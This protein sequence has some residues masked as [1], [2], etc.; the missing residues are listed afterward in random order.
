MNVEELK[1]HL[2][3]IQ[4]IPDEKWMDE[5]DERKQR[6]LEFHNLHRDKSE[7]ENVDSDTFE[8]LYGNKKYYSTV[9]RSREYFD[10]WI[11][12]HAE[13]EIV[14]DYAC[15][16]G[17][18]TL[19]AAKAGAKL[20]IGFD[21]SDVSVGNARAAAESEGLEN[22][23]FFQADAEDTKLPDGSVDV[24][25]C[26]GMLHHLDLSY[27]FPEMRRILAP[28]GRILAVE[29]L[30]YNPAI[31]LY[32]KMTPN[33]RTEWEADHILSLED[34]DF[35]RYFFDIGEVRFWHIT[36]YVGAHFPKAL[37]FFH[38]IDCVLER[39]PGVRLMAW[40]FTFELL[41]KGK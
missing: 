29:A 19:R 12:K 20:A 16:N 24:I 26:S 1:S 9:E 7:V 27:A 38:M 2:K 21:I 13:N 8:K 41:A 35:A 34:I 3:D 28:G 5:L 6:E 10:N 11:E 37:P 32:R 14:L 23:F 15:G 17:Q 40:I 25:I 30:D 4:K 36:S 39:I 31:K 22:T 33:M 18:N